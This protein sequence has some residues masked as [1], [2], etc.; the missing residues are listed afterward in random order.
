MIKQNRP[1]KKMNRALGTCV[2]MTKKLHLCHRAPCLGIGLNFGYL[3]IQASRAYSIR[4]VKI[5]KLPW[6][7]LKHPV[8]KHKA[9]HRKNVIL[10]LHFAKTHVLLPGPKASPEP[11][12]SIM[13]RIIHSTQC[14]KSLLSTY[15]G[16]GPLNFNIC[17]PFLAWIPF[18]WITRQIPIVPSNSVQM[19]SLLTLSKR[20][21]SSFIFTSNS[22]HCALISA[23]LTILYALKS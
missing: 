19:Q 12:R 22:I 11:N 21:V 10:G 1:G 7:T 17:S 6:S 2:T 16:P 3:Y 5:S 4:L 23:L 14:N 20:Y 15:K 13:V 9:W 8:S 18:I